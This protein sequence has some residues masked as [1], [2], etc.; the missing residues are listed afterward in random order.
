MLCYSRRVKNS[1]ANREK[2][3]RR[4]RA[5]AAAA[6]LLAAGQARADAGD[7]LNFVAGTT[8]RHEDNLFRLPASLTPAALQVLIGQPAK[9]DDVR[10]GYLGIQLDKAYSQQQLHLDVTATTYRYKNFSRLNFDAF[11]YA[12]Y[13]NWHVTQRLSGKLSADH[14]QTQANFAGTTNYSGNNTT[15]TESRRFDADW[16]ALGGWHLLGSASQYKSRNSQLNVAEDSFIQNSG[17]TGIRYVA[18]S[19]ST[20][21]L[22]AR[23][24]RGEYAERRLN[25]ASLL[26]TGYR[27]ADT[28]LQMAWRLSGKSRL[29]GRL[30]RLDRKHDNFAQRDYSGTAGRLD[31]TL[32]PTGKFLA[33]LSAARGIASYQETAHSYYVNDSLTFAPVWQIG[34]K[35]AL[36][37]NLEQSRRD[38]L[39]GAVVPPAAGRQ[40]RTSTAQLSLDWSPLRALVLTATLQRDS[41]R[42]N[43]ANLDFKANAASITAQISF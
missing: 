6:L 15:T 23:K 7:T 5:L 35:T 29:D 12:G 1:R 19:G 27:Q 4:L 43:Q 40:D 41:R 37:L 36:R 24:S 39:G 34:P 28:E 16:W 31:Y 22:L 3:S 11:D 2:P 33:K 25:A 9:S 30:T 17:D 18:E 14:K 42:S 10:V 8:V 13:W 32:T 38:Y 26:D 20:L 21:T